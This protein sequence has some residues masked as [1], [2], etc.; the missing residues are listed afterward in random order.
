MTYSNN[1]NCCMLIILRKQYACEEKNCYKEG[2]KKFHYF[3]FTSGIACYGQGLTMPWQASLFPSVL[4]V[5]L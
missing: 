1:N 4:S 2:Y 3:K 5:C